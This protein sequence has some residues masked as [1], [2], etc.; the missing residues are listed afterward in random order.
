MGK[1]LIVTNLLVFSHTLL[2]GS[3]HFVGINR[4]S[5]N[6]HCKLR[7]EPIE[8]KWTEKEIKQWMNYSSCVEDWNNYSI[9]YKYFITTIHDFWS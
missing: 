8:L 9:I 1:D 6:E 7:Q 4:M 2:R 3:E 5:L